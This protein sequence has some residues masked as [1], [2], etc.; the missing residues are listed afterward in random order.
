VS[1]RAYEDRPGGWWEHLQEQSGGALDAGAEA[2]E[3]TKT[4]TL[5]RPPWVQQHPSTCPH[6][7]GHGGCVV[8]TMRYAPRSVW[9]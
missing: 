7:S 2:P 6:G 1:D 9:Q 4:A 5:P 8:H 3:E